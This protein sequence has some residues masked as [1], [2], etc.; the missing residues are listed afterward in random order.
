MARKTITF[1]VDDFE[2][3]EILRY[4]RMKGYSNV[5]V[6][7]Y[8]AVFQQLKNRHGETMP[9]DRK[10][11]RSCDYRR[12]RKEVLKRDG[13]KC[14]KCGSSVNLDAHHIKLFSECPELRLEVSNGITLCAYCHRIE[15][16]RV[17]ITINIG[18]TT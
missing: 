17:S 7:A 14:Q 1:S 16:S 10:Q 9:E 18:A 12:W 13:Y 3:N 8:R 11:R 2:Y 5:S 4:A 6:F 15:H